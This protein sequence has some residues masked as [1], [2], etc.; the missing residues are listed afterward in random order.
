MGLLD[1]S[2]AAQSPELAFRRG[3]LRVKRI[4]LQAFDGSARPKGL[5]GPATGGL[6]LFKAANC[7][8]H[9]RVVK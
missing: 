9:Q 7:R 8:H 3:V 4:D 6:K 5:P 1:K 2:L